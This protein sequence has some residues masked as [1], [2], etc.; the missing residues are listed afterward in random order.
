[1]KIQDY[2]AWLGNPVTRW[3]FA[4]LQDYAEKLAQENGRAV[5]ERGSNMQDDYMILA[6]QAGVVQG[7]E[8]AITADLLADER[9]EF[10]DETESNGQRY[11]N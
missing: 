4:Q 1:M 9:E 3:V 6:K 7:V 11:P 8:F 5:G 10:I 2:D